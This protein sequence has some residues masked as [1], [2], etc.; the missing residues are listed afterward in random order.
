MANYYPIKCPYCLKAHNNATVRFRLEEAHETHKKKIAR[1]S[2]GSIYDPQPEVGSTWYNT[3]NTIDDNWDTDDTNASDAQNAFS[4]DSGRPRTLPTSGYYTYPELQEIF[5]PENVRTETKTVIALPALTSDEYNGDLIIGVTIKVTEGDMEIEKTMRNRYCDCDD[6]RKINASSGSIPS[7]VILIMGSSDSGKTAYLISLYHALSQKSRYSFPPTPDPNKAIASLWLSVASE[8][9]QERDIETMT[10]ELFSD[11]KL[12]R[13]TIDM[14]NEP[15]TME[16]TIRFNKTGLVNKALL[17]IRDM[18]GE[19][20]TRRERQG[21]LQR[22]MSQFP[23]FDGFL[24]TFDPMTFDN[25]V[26]PSEDVDKDRQRRSQVSRLR[27]AIMNNI[28]P[29]MANNMIAQPTVALVTKGDMFFDREYVQ[30]LRSRGISYAAPLL[31]VTQKESYDKPYFEEVNEGARMVVQKLSGNIADLM[32]A[33]FSNAYFSM[34]SAL[35]R[36][37]VEIYKDRDGN[38]WVRTPSAINPWHVADPMLRLLMKLHIVPPLDETNSRVKAGET[39]DER[40]ARVFRNR[41][42][43]NEW[44]AKYCS[45]G[46][47]VNLV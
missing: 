41:G 32:G 24:I 4:T 40:N 34:V 14:T 20:F 46:S 21:E 15:L 26:F 2:G 7:Y 18:P 16:V 36:N 22:I 8:G 42:I 29:T 19:Y 27:Q 5:G 17:F 25:T 6:D 35:C 1:K 43:I 9:Y 13:T 10:E 28:A 11:G 3:D 33:H 44:G 45:G 12:P 23:R 39:Q 37:P 30:A 47:N 38:R 31:T